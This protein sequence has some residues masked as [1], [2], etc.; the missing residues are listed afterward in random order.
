MNS[1]GPARTEEPEQDDAVILADSLREDFI[2]LMAIYDSQL[3]I[4]GGASDRKESS[5]AAAR[6]AA[7]RGLRLSDDLRELLGKNL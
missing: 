4:G 7:E 2:K 1:Q 5:I 3:T 6:A